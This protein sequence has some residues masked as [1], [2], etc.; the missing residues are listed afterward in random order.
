MSMK[1][2]NLD[3]HL[4]EIFKQFIAIKDDD[5]K[6]SQ[7]VFKAVFDEVKS[8][9]GE[10]CNYF[11]KYSSQILIAGSVDDGI[12]VS[13]LDEFDMDIV[14][15]LPINQS[16]ESE[17]GIVMEYDKPGFVKM[18]IVEGFD[19][20]DKQPEWEKCNVVTRDWRDQ[21]KYFLQNKFRQWLHG[22]VQKALNEMNRRVTV[23]GIDYLLM[24]KE[25]GPAYT[26]NIKNSK[27]QE[28]FHLDVD[29]VPVI[30]FMIPRWPAEYKSVQDSSVKEWYVVPK[31]NKAL[32][33]ETQQSRCWRLSF[34]HFEKEMMKNRQQLKTTIR[35]MKKL[36]DTLDMKSI[37]SYYI[38]TLFLW[39]IEANDNKYWQTKLSTL[40]HT[41][42]KEFHDAI[43]KKN[44]P[45]F[46]H[47]D[48]NL[49]ESLNPN[50]QKI[51]LDKLASVLKSLE[52]NDV[53]AVVAVLLTSAELKEFRKSEF[54]LT[55]AAKEKDTVDGL[56]ATASAVAKSAPASSSE[57]SKNIIRALI[58]KVDKLTTAVTALQDRVQLL[59]EKINTAQGEDAIDES[60]MDTCAT[61]P[62][63]SQDSGVSLI[64]F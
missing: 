36:R 55:V 54:Y 51:Y 1:K 63:D 33:D 29:L 64:D 41:M 31:P 20:M 26:L 23:N 19:Y 46:W 12:K 37:A 53:D 2:K 40:F 24:Y 17:K 52:G 50:V 38:K 21:D 6:L 22:I 28:K 30:K 15:R 8:K 25:A 9:M 34:Q 42:V 13:K 47:K 44:I 43:E 39:K 49:I 60:S 48:N 57:D 45:Y 7:D 18:R 27:G 61:S 58:G 62:T 16:D 14:I 3:A 10:K 4:A 35:L 32:N 59:E 56:T 11:K 5:Y